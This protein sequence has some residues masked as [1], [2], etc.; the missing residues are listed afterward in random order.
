MSAM[1]FLLKTL[2]ETPFFAFSSQHSSAPGPHPSSKPAM[3]GLV[4]LTSQHSDTDFYLT[5]PDLKE[6]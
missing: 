6:S 3:A 1:L 2:R 4:F 5:P